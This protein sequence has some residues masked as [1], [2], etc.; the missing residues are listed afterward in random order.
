ML[1]RAG[2]ADLGGG[3]PGV[4]PAM[5][6]AAARTDCTIHRN[7][8]VVGVSGRQ[9]TVMAFLP[10]VPVAKSSNAVGTSASAPPSPARCRTAAAPSGLIARSWA[11]TS[12]V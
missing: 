4:R 8:F 3:M 6:S 12:P 1:K 7:A 11:A 10:R 9:A 5:T 2:A